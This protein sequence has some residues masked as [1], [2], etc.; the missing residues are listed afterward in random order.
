M[1]KKQIFSTQ[2]FKPNMRKSDEEGVVYSYSFP[3]TFYNNTPTLYAE[4][5]ITKLDALKV[6]VDVYLPNGNQYPAWYSHEFGNFTILD[7][8]KT[9]ITNRIRRLTEDEY[10]ISW[11]GLCELQIRRHRRIEQGKSKSTLRLKR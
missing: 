7:D 8:I 11:Q 9:T 2:Q 6:F 5:S 1:Y 3:V 10:D 4:L